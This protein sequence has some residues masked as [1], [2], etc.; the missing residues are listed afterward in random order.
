MMVPA[1]SVFSI[2]FSVAGLLILYVTIE[3]AVKNGINKSVMGQYFDQKSGTTLQKTKSFLD[4][5][6]DKD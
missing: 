2:I 1:I 5:D 6:L 3:T 4:D